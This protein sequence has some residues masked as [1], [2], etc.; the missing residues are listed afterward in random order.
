MNHDNAATISKKTKFPL[1]L[2]VAACTAV[3]VLT[4]AWYSQR[5]AVDEIKRSQEEGTKSIKMELK[6]VRDSQ[7]TRQDMSEWTWQAKA[8]NPTLKLPVVSAARR[9]GGSEDQ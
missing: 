4:G 7:W 3:A 9:K 8:D 5:A 2:V 6:A 1:E